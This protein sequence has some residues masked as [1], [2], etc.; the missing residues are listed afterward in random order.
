M[1]LSRPYVTADVY[2]G[3]QRLFA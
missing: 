3:V 1:L 2:N